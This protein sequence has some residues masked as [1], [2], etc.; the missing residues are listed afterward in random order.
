[1]SNNLFSILYDFREFLYE[2]VWGIRLARELFTAFKEKKKNNPRTVFLVLTP[3]H[4]NLGDHAIV[5]AVADLLTRNGIDYVEI[6]TMQLTWLQKS[7]CLFI[8]NG[9]P[10]LINGGGNMGTLWFDA[11]VLMRDIIFH[12]PKSPI[13][14]LP[15]TIYYEDTDF[16]R[17]EFERSKKIYNAHKKLYLYAREKKSYEIMKE[18]YQTVKLIPDMVFSMN[19]CDEALCQERK[20]CI[21]CIRNDLESIYT[22]QQKKSLYD[23]LK[24]VFGDDIYLSDMNHSSCISVTQREEALFQKRMEFQNAQLVITDRLHG[25][26]L[27]AITGTPCV[28]INSLSPKVKGCYEWIKHL[29]YIKFCDSF[30]DILPAV[31]SILGGTYCYENKNF[32]CYFDDLISDIKKEVT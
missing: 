14:I 18:A 25:M 32:M 12:N 21:L 28:V 29:G 11:E 13:F 4:T 6:T 27:S 8:M 31:H 15:N 23:M 9:W 5:T 30:S 3:E 24:P 22:E 16:G 26:I 2:K 7:G 1:M 20:G 17:R 19:W 10:I